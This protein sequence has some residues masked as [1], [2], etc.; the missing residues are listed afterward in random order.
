MVVRRWP[1]IGFTPATATEGLP[2]APPLPADE[3]ATAALTA[4][5]L[6]ASG[7]L[8]A[9]GAGDARVTDTVGDDGDPTRTETLARREAPPPGAALL[10]VA[11]GDGTP[12]AP[13][14]LRG[15]EPAAWGV[16]GWVEG[17]RAA[18]AGPGPTLPGKAPGVAPPFAAAA[19]EKPAMV[20]RSAAVEVRR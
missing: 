3:G 6:P 16:A 8:L 9:E 19:A 2:P 20:V 12:G 14:G 1:P 10:P 15:A 11:T 4:R 18:L 13:K 5:A 17:A 7:D